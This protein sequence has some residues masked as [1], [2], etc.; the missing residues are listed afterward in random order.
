MNNL[1]RPKSV[2]PSHANEVATNGGVVITET[3]TAQFLK[4]MEMP[5][6]VPLSGRTMQF[7]SRGHCV[8][9]CN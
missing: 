2:I 7:D 5:G 6:H 3:R 4:A 8:A 1:V 9:E